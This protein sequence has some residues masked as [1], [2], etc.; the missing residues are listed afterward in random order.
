M[1]Y[2]ANALSL[3]IEFAFGCAVTLFVFRLLAEAV[4]ADFY[5]PIC[6]FLYRATNPVLTP[7]RRVIPTWRR[8]NLAAL[9]IAWLLEVIKNFLLRF[10]VPEFW[11]SNLGTLVL[12]VAD[13]LNFFMFAYLVMIF[14]WALLSY[15]NVDARNPL[16]PLL[17]KIVDPVLKPF[18]KVL[19]LIGGFDLS[20]VLAILVILLVQTVVVAWLVDLGHTI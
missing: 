18:R 12:G 5:N 16:V 14:V 9:L 15:V 8:I 7:I 17:G 13:L 3:L 20:P 4:R 11:A 1:S 6:Q 10:T 19:P 2:L